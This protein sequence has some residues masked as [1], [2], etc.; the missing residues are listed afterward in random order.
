MLTNTH[1]F[2]EAAQHFKKYGRYCDYPQGT[3]SHYIFWKDELEKCIY[4][5]QIGD[6]RITGDHYYY[7]NYVQIKITQEIKN[8]V[9]GK[10]NKKKIVDFPKFWD[11]D[12][13]FFWAKEIAVN[14][15]TEEFVKKLNL[16]WTPLSLKGGHNL[17]VGKARRK[18]FSY[19]NAAMISNGYNTIR[20]HKSLV[21]AFEKKF[22]YPDG[23]MKMVTDNM[24][25]LNKETAWRKRRQDINQ[26][27][28]RKASYKAYEN[29]VEVHKGYMSEV[30]ALTF[31]DNP[32]AARGKDAD[33]VVL[34][35]CGAFPN[36]KDTFFSTKPCV[37]DGGVQT[38]VMILFGTGGDMEG[39][40]IDF[41]SMFYNPEPYNILPFDNIWDDGAQGMKSGLFFP[42]YQN[43]VGYMDKDGNSLKEE[44]IKAEQAKR[45][46]IKNTSKDPQAYDKHITEYPFK[47][48][49][50]FL[51]SNINLFPTAALSEWRNRIEQTGIF[52]NMGVT[53][54][55]AKTGNGVVKFVRNENKRPVFKFPADKGSDLTGCVVIYQVPYRGPDGKIPEDMYVAVHDPYGIDSANGQ[56]LGVTYIIKR[57]NNFSQ[58]DDMIVASY[59]GRPDSL[60]E[61]NEEMFLLAEYYNARI[62]FENDRGE[63]I[64]YAKRTG[65]L[66]LLHREPEIYDNDDG[67]RFKTLGRKFGIS[68]G[69]KERKK[70]AEIYLRDWLKRK[71][72]V[73]QKGFIERNLHKIYD[74]ALI[75]ELIRFSRDGNFDRVSALLVWVFQEKAMLEQD[76]E[77]TDQDENTESFWDRDFFSEDNPNNPNIDGDIVY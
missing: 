61:Y 19:K 48:K 63:V 43:K 17:M 44:A 71:R 31:K 20:N 74:P 55:M 25:F 30:Q 47:P 6:V 66:W 15:S 39:G 34:E 38:G 7:L 14:G 68:M 50:A 5:H 41:E 40:T 49:E 56:S 9:T 42:D 26:Q 11:G 46:R 18:G 1:L 4:G 60:D 29:G 36:L 52:K 23:T 73:N 21:C 10:V 16:Q 69:S 77:E 37:E 27:A 72:G 59:V 45:D 22:L 57:M 54:E 2:S 51:R 33:I 24:D 70:M 8:P 3:P 32:D 75:D 62:A 13:N 53:G 35:E 28:H 64:P 12:Y 67:T 65:R 76:V 58:P